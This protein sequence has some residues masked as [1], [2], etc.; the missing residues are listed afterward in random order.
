MPLQTLRKA[1]KRY[2]HPDPKQRR[3]MAQ[4][5]ELHKVNL[6]TLNA[7]FRSVRRAGGFGIYLNYV[8]KGPKP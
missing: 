4:L 7:L 3:S 6:N 5:A 2:H 8:L 1:W